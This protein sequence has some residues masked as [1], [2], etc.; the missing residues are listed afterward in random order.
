MRPRIALEGD[1][2]VTP[3]DS[4]EFAHPHNDARRP[5]LVKTHTV[6]GSHEINSF[7][8]H[9]HLKDEPWVRQIF[10]DEVEKRCPEAVDRAENARGGRPG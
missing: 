10:L 7:G 3:A 6:D 2:S 8:L 5:R 9:A 4:C 1:A